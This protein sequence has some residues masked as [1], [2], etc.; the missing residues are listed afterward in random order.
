MEKNIF[1]GRKKELEDLES[2]LSKKSSSLLVVKGRR[3]I[4]KSRL[5]EEFSKKMKT[6]KFIGLPPQKKTS[7]QSQLDEFSSQLCPQIGI[8]QI[9]LD[10]WSPDFSMRFK[11]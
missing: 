10:D 11:S 5:L 8:P 1:I 7:K 3:R 2:I 4:G 6:F 9:K